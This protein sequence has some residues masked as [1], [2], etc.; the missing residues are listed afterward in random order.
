MGQLATH[1]VDYL[2]FLGYSV[3]LWQTLTSWWHLR[4]ISDKRKESLLTA[5][6]LV[7]MI[8][9]LAFVGANAYML[10]Y[11]GETLLS[12]R[13]FQIFVMANFFVYW[14]ILTLLRKEVTDGPPA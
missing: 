2:I 5:I 8:S 7:M 4:K 9:I 13:L 1:F 3:L 11:R 6:L 14:L 12:M 10:Q